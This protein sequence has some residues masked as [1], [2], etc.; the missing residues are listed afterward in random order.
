MASAVLA[1]EWHLKQTC[2]WV[3]ASTR[4]VVLPAAG[5]KVFASPQAL[6]VWAPQAVTFTPLEPSITLGILEMT[7]RLAVVGVVVHVPL[8]VSC[9]AVLLRTGALWPMPTPNTMWTYHPAKAF[10]VQALAPPTADWVSVRVVAVAA[11][12]APPF[13]RIEMR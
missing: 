3:V 5:L 4:A 12:T 6:G 1:A 9:V 2:H 10:A 13:A 8:M 7:Y 11:V